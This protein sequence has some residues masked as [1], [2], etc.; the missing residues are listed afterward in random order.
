M[1]RITGVCNNPSGLTVASLNSNTDAFLDLALSCAGADSIV[2][3]TGRGDGTFNT[4]PTTISTAPNAT[5]PLAITHG[6]FNEDGYLD[7]AIAST[8]GS[9]V[10]TYSGNGAGAFSNEQAYSTSVFR[11][12]HWHL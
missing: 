6:D 2:V 11:Q 9:V 10:A 5:L 12:I 4:P 8:G 1:S 7:L 3:Y